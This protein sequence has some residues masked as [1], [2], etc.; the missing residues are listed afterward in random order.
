MNTNDKI[1]N[2]VKNGIGDYQAG[3]NPEIESIVIDKKGIDEEVIRFISA[4]NNEPEDILK[5]RLD[6]FYKWQKMKEPHWAL[7]DYAP[8]DY[9][10]IYYFS[11]PK[12]ENPE[13]DAKIDQTYERLGIPLHERD[14]LK[15]QAVDAVVDSVSV[16]TTYGKKLLELGII[17]CPISV[18]I[19][20]YPDLVKKFF[21]KVVPPEDNFFACLNA[22]VFSDGTFV[23]IPKNV[24]CPIELSSYFRLQTEKLGQFERTLIIADEGSEVSYLEGCSAP[25]RDT[26]QLHSGVVELVA[27]K[28]AKI[29]YSTVQNWYA[30]DK[31]GKGG[32]YNFVTKRGICFED[33]IISWTQLEVGAVKTWKYPSCILKGDRSKGEFFSVAIT[34]NCQ[35]ADTGTKM[36]HIGKDTTSTIISKGISLGKSK[37]GYRGLVKVLNSADNAKNFTKCD[38]LVVGDYASSLALPDIINMNQSAVVEHEASVAS[39][40]EEQLFFMMQRGMSEDKA[41]GLVVNGFCSDI[42]RKLPAEFA[43]EAKELINISIEG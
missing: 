25:I 10:D 18:A 22:A 4:K 24:K 21:A 36:V 11:R 5:F 14:I 35:M 34:N 39:V 15:G 40:S 3:F 32:I 8:I 6:S 26:N 1:K 27:C 29:K 13:V 42:I 37:N 2:I 17:F 19:Q 20:K 30:G 31:D 33:A 38:N 28:G 12:E 23:Y 43:V 9:N 16:K 41:L 7:F